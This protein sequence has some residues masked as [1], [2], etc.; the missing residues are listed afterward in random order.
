MGQKSYKYRMEKVLEFKRQKEDEEKEKLA[1]LMQEEQHERQ[2]KAE[3]EQTLVNVHVELK[4][5]RLSGALNIAEL[6]WF[7]EHVKSLERK[8]AYQELRLK[9]LAIRIIEQ[10]DALTKAAQERQAY[11]KHREKDH[12]E[13]VKEQ[14]AI[15]NQLLDELATIKFAREARIRLEEQG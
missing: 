10:R 1:K 13:W 2:V 7:P 3:L 6:R 4:T 9:E 14:D 8:I 5:K 11:D 15:E 12:E